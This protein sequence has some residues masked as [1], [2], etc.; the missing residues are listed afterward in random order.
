VDDV[1]DRAAL[2]H[3]LGDV[4]RL[5]IV[6]ALELSDLTFQEAAHAAMVPS[7]LAAHHIGILERA[8][9]VT[10]RVSDG[11]RRR[12]YLTLR[13][14]RFDGLTGHARL[15]SGSLLF[16]CTHN[17]AR[18]QFAAALWRA[19]T[20]GTAESAGTEPA[21]RVHRRAVEAA[22]AFGLDLGHATPR[23]YHELGGPSELIVS[24][25]DRA[26]ETELP[27]DAPLLHWSVP[28]PVA[29]GTRS[30]FREAFTTIASRVDRLA[31]T[32]RAAEART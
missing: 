21:T 28:D 16:I 30:A 8:G 3:A 17:S 26:R 25:C 9:V 24:V 15:R 2:H 4:A 1:S 32:T 13:P 12:R 20:G 31:H 18:S 22:R 7:N 10:R 11:D 19:R 29:V 23:G 14:E 27:F 5:R 6:D